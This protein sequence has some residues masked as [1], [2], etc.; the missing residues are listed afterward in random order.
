MTATQVAE[1]FLALVGP[2]K[3]GINYLNTAIRLKN[4][5][6]KHVLRKQSATLAAPHE[7]LE[8]FTNEKDPKFL[9]GINGLVL[10]SPAELNVDLAKLFLSYHL[11]LIIEKP[12]CFSRGEA[13]ALVSSANRHN[14][15][16]ITNYIHLYSS[17]FQEL[18]ERV[19][20]TEIFKIEATSGNKGPV[21]SNLPAFWDWLP[22][23]LS[24]ILSI[25]NG[26]PPKTVSLDLIEGSIDQGNAHNICWHMKWGHIPIKILSGN[27]FAK[28]QR[29]FRVYTNNG[30]YT[31]SDQNNRNQVFF[32]KNSD[33]H[34]QKNFDHGLLIYTSAQSPLENLL[35]KFTFLIK[36][37]SMPSSLMDFDIQITTILEDAWLVLLKNSES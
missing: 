25:T 26:E 23:D 24:M 3:W 20:D 30:I 28:K 22:H 16:F 21:R 17:A 6:F 32:S 18:S 4:I 10:A 2:G 1:C 12:L 37:N 8:V 27:L 34:S 11:P 7:K 31:Y 35:K 33:N 19:K 29:I 9:E 14:S 15:F 5:S 13:S 36:D